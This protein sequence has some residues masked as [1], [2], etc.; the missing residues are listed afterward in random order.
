MV[1]RYTRL[2]KHREDHV[3]SWNESLYIDVGAYG[4]DLGGGYILPTNVDIYD[5]VLWFEFSDANT[6]YIFLPLQ[7][8]I[9]GVF[10][11]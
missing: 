5:G 11:A 4:D 9:C 1:G 10:T 8:D 2:D 6:N 7:F 3:I